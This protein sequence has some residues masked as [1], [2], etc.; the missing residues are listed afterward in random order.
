MNVTS[1]V[2]DRYIEMENRKRALRQKT[3]DDAYRKNAQYFKPKFNPALEEL[4]DLLTGKKE[5]EHQP[6]VQAAIRNLQQRKDYA[7]QKEDPSLTVNNEVSSNQLTNMASHDD[8]YARTLAILE[9]VRD[10]ALASENPSEQDLQVAATTTETIQKVQGQSTP[11]SEL[12]NVIQ[13]SE[14]EKSD[15]TTA[16]DSATIAQEKEKQRLFKKAISLY[17]FHMQMA[18]QRF[19]FTEPTIYRAV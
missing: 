5:R 6:E 10:A 11:K 16:V 13:M 12:S 18:K 8:T 9:D 3:A 17:S 19:Q 4:V 2:N 14:H 1:L 7:V 15:S